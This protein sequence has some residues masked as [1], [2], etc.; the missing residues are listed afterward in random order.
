[1]T[2]RKLKVEV[3]WDP[4]ASLLKYPTFSNSA[5]MYDSLITLPVSPRAVEGALEC[6]VQ[7]LQLHLLCQL[8]DKSCLPTSAEIGSLQSRRLASCYVLNRTTYLLSVYNSLAHYLNF[9]ACKAQGGHKL[10]I[11]RLGQFSHSM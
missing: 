3:D 9:V 7:N 8:L 2:K 11:G 10:A 6:R 1:M 5:K 4:K